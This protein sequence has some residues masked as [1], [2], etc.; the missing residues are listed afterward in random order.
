[1]HPQI[2]KVVIFGLVTLFIVSW[3]SFLLPRR[4]T[5]SPDA[6]IT[7]NLGESPIFNETLGVP[8]PNQHM[9]SVSW[10]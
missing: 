4:T 3:S 7:Q 2:Q 9:L 1:M 6:E 5:L 10:D 8:M